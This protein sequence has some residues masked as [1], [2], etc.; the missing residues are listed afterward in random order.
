M[1]MKV[2]LVS[3]Q[4]PERFYDFVKLP[5]LGVAYIAAALRNAGHQVEILDTTLFRKPEE[6]FDQT[7]ARFNPT[8]AGFSASTSTFK[9]ALSLATRLRGARPKVQI[10]FGGVHP[11]WRPAEVAAEPAIDYVVFGEGEV[12]VVE[13]FDA[14]GKGQKPLEVEGVAFRDGGRVIVNAPRPL[15][16]NLD[17]LPI[18]AYD[19]LPISSYSTPETSRLPTMSMITSRGCP[20]HCTFCDAHLVFGREYR[21]YSS[22][23]TFEEMRLLK[24]RFGVRQIAFKDSEFTLNVARVEGLCDRILS[25]RLDLPWSCNGRIGR[26]SLPLLRKMRK[27][28]C[29]MIGFGVESA[30]PDI[31]A[32][33]K[34]QITL[35]EARETFRLTRKA[36]IRTAANFLVGSPGETFVSLEKMLNLAMELKPDF[37][38][39][40]RLVPYPGTALHEMAEEYGWVKGDSDT[41]LSSC[42]EAMNA[43]DL[44]DKQLEQAHRRLYRRFYL[45][46]GYLIHRALVTT[47]HGWKT[48]FR[49][50]WKVLKGK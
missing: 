29:R 41:A 22:D 46:P 27:A 50:L 31:L 11:T 30:D 12:T 48:N 20:Y 35:D 42:G 9:P 13:L 8:I 16:A 15:V 2:L 7:V 19:L 10:V 28:G 14:L 45:R 23:R 36:R 39:F 26:L 47:P 32:A 5:P 40:A 24:K 37:V 34:K 25:E 6:V 3:P 43:T 4:N 38:N 18:P 17:S 1:T 44:T 21:F 33:L 49:G